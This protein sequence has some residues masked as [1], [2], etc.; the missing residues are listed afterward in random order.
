MKALVW[1]LIV[2]VLNS[3]IDLAHSLQKH[4]YPA[5]DTGEATAYNEINTLYELITEVIIGLEDHVGEEDRPDT[6]PGLK[7]TDSWHIAFL[8][9]EI[10]LHAVSLYTYADFPV[11]SLPSVAISL[12]VPPPNG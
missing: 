10:P 3:S 6:D 2:M 4:G 12:V 8:I 7:K 9:S 5:H 11:V 1:L